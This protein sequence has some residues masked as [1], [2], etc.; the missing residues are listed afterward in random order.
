MRQTCSSEE[1]AAAIADARR[2]DRDIAGCRHELKQEEVAY[3][4]GSMDLKGIAVWPGG[5]DTTGRGLPC[6]LVAHTVVGLPEDFMYYKLEKV[7][8]RGYLVGFHAVFCAMQRHSVL[9]APTFTCLQCDGTLG[10]LPLCL[11]PAHR[12]HLAWTCLGEGGPCGIRTRRLQ[13]VSL[14]AVTGPSWWRGGLSSF[15]N[16]PT[17][18]NTTGTCLK[19]IA[20]PV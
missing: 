10:S 13:P 12:R 8:S 6:I 1:A 3:E 5:L 2:R 18:C 20:N 7:A 11:L 16:C 15:A 9:H 14:F 4:H 19:E 17:S